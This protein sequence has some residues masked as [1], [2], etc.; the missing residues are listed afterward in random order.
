MA[1]YILLR[2]MLASHIGIT[3]EKKEFYIAGKCAV[4]AAVAVEPVPVITME[5]TSRNAR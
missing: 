4:E 2:I 1:I 5:K 3:R